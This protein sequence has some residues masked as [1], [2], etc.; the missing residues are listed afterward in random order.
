MCP[1]KPEMGRFLISVMAISMVPTHISTAFAQLLPI[2]TEY[3]LC[4]QIVLRRKGKVQVV[5]LRRLQWHCKA[6]CP[7]QI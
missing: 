1:A 6:A 7:I 5:G 2:S 4:Q 3:N